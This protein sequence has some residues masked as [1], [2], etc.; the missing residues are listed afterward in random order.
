MLSL[1]YSVYGKKVKQRRHRGNYKHLR[2]RHRRLSSS[3]LRNIP[4]LIRW[5]RA[6]RLPFRRVKDTNI[7]R[8]I[9]RSP[10][11]NDKNAFRNIYFSVLSCTHGRM[12]VF[13]R[14][15]PGLYNLVDQSTLD[16]IPF[17]NKSKA[18]KYIHLLYSC[19]VPRKCVSVCSP[20]TRF[21]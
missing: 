9:Y 14:Y 10:L 17:T 11:F 15:A 1:R 20:S 21:F 19:S 12:C 4:S 6:R 18:S 13:G 3:L 7:M 16:L 8:K 5:L 2:A